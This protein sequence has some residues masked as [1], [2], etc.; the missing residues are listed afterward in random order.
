M[1]WTKQFHPGPGQLIGGAI[2][3]LG[4]LLKIEHG[5]SRLRFCSEVVTARQQ[6]DHIAHR[7]N[8]QVLEDAH[9]FWAAGKISCYLRSAPKVC[10][11]APSIGV[12]LVHDLE[13]NGPVLG[14]VHRNMQ[15]Y[16]DPHHRMAS[17]AL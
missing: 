9:M 13:A 2:Q 4:G 12:G 5:A 7:L 6:T 15:P 1:L 16:T 14:G 17:A 11:G 3:K 8:E 10:G